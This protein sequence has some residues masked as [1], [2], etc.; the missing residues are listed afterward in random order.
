[1]HIGPV[2]MC[3]CIAE[4]HLPYQL[5][6]SKLDAAPY[7]TRTQGKLTVNTV[8]SALSEVIVR[9]ETL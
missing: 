6:L 1:V 4:L 7:S 5:K 9:S 2:A 3:Q 8:T